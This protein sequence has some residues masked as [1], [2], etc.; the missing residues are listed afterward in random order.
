MLQ[1]PVTLTIQPPFHHLAQMLTPLFFH[2]QSRHHH[3]PQ[4]PPHIEY[5]IPRISYD[6]EIQLEK[7]NAEYKAKGTHLNPSP[8]LK[9]HILEALADKIIKFKAYPTDLDLNA[10][11]EALIQKHPCLRELGSFNGCYGWKISL[12]Y[13]MANFRTK[14]RSVGCPEVSVNSLKNKPQ[15][16]CHAALKVKKPRRAEVNYCPEYPR[17]ETSDSLERERVELLSEIKKRNNEKVVKEKIQKTFSYRRQEVVQENP[18]VAEFKTRWPA[19]FSVSEINAEFMRITTYPLQHR[20]FAMLDQYSDRLMRLFLSKGGVTG[21][22]IR[23]I[24]V[25]ISQNASIHTRREC[26][27]KALCTYLNEDH[28]KLVKEFM[29]SEPSTTKRDMEQTVMA[30]YVI[31]SEGAEATDD[32]ADVGVLIEGVEVLQDLG[33]IALACAM[34]FGVIYT[35]N[36]SYPQYLKCT[37]EV[38]QK[39]LMNLDGQRLS[40]KAQALKNKL[41]E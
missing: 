30:V 10:V 14:L 13:K 23:N 39:V 19:L 24:M 27:L 35:L 3:H 5:L 26:I 41:F 1:Q 9:S 28:E 16:Q 22:K 4:D 32:P 40:P 37:F 25:V 20:F 31:R 18:M 6:S 17:G 8:K 2:L 33:N 21:R 36:L 15:D 7:A 12:K 11:A 34:L 29:D 38:L